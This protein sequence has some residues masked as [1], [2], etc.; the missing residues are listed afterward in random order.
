MAS[1]QPKQ[2]AIPRHPLPPPIDEAGRERVLNMPGVIV[3]RRDPSKPRVRFKPG[4]RVRE[5][6]DV[7]KRIHEDDPLIRAE[8][9][10]TDP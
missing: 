9:A 8:S 5:G 6:Y 10:V 2:D 7:M 4:I 3:H 1:R